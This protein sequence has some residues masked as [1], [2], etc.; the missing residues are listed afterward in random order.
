MTDAECDRSHA[1]KSS[2][3]AERK[4][5]WRKLRS[6][7]ILLFFYVKTRY[8][9]PW[10]SREQFDKWQERKIRRQ[11]SKIRRRSSFYR[12]QWKDQPL[13]SWRDFPM[14]DKNIMMKHFNALN[15]AGIDRDQAMKLAAEAEQTRNFSPKLKGI[16]I[17]LSSG[18]SGNCGLF[19]V[20]EFEQAA[21]AGTMLAKV[22]PKPIWKGD[23]IAFFLR[24]NSNLYESVRSS[25]L[26]F[27]YFDL[28]EPLEKHVADLMQYEPTI[29]VAP[30]SY[31]R[32]LA[33]QKQAGVLMISPYRLISIAEVLD[34]LDAV[35]I[36]AAFGTKLHQ[37]YQCTEGFLASTCRH[38][39]LHLNE[40][41][42]H[43]EKE[44]IAEDAS[45]RKFVPI[46]TDFFRITQPIVRYRLNDVLIE[47]KNR[48]PCGSVFTLLERIEGRWDD[49][50]YGTSTKSRK[51]VAIFPDYITRAVIAASA[52][53]DEY[54][55]MQLDVHNWEIQLQLKSDVSACEI[56]AASVTTVHT[57]AKIE[58]QVAAE[59]EKLLHKLDCI[60]PNLIFTAYCF[61]PGIRKLKR[62][63]RLYTHEQN[64]S[65]SHE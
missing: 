49:I 46:V 51:S 40:D 52:D 15:T 53:I 18:T 34:P 44:Y 50:F 19:L 37:V 5:N 25:K 63:E 65:G 48:C 57:R 21:W 38:G 1:A 56:G 32:L 8:R 39:Q 9:L 6:L 17:G 29:V 4:S 30:P 42:V 13:T 60:V 41:I 64:E 12:G 45:N 61:Q 2:E 36:E 7:A 31:L 22:L 10:R 59:I 43:I 28:L 14:I 62:V 58:A 47:Q 23:K 54:R 27:R 20:S 55:V 16:T 11:L 33:A 35:Y 26:Q 24:A 3:A